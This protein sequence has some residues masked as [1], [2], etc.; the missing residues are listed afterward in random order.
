M[1]KIYKITLALLAFTSFFGTQAQTTVTIPAANTAG[2]GANTTIHRK[3]LG[4]RDSYERTALK[5][6]QA[7]IGMLGNITAIG[8][9]CDTVNAPGKTPVKIYMKEVQDS[10]F[11]ASTVAA[12]ETNATLVYA[13][14]LQ[15]SS[16]VQN[17][18]V[19]ITLTTPFLHATNSNI[20]IIVETNTGGT[21][22]SDPTNLAKGFRYSA[23]SGTR[24]EYWQ[25]NH[26]APVTN[27]NVTS[28]NRPNIQL[29]IATATVC[30]SP[31][32]SGTTTATAASVCYGNTVDL[33]LNGN[34]T[35]ISQTYQWI[36]SSD[37]TTWSAIS[38]ATSYAYVA[39][40]NAA[41]YYACVLTCSSMSDTSTHLQVTLN[42]FYA[43]YCTNGIG[44]GCTAATVIDSVA[45]AGTTL[46]NGPLVCPA[47]NYIAYPSSGSTTASLTQGLTYSLSTT[48][49][50][51]LISSVW[52]DYNQN[53]TFETTEWKQICTTATAGTNVITNLSIP[54]TALVGQT[55]MRIRTRAS[56]SQNDSTSA[57]TTFGSGETQDYVVTIVAGAP[58]TAP[59]TS[60]TTVASAT[61]ICPGGIVNLSLNGNSIGSGQTFQWQSSTNGTTWTPI[62]GATLPAYTATVST[63][64]YYSCVLTCSAQSSTSSSVLI[65]MNSFYQCYCSSGIG[66][67]CTAATAIDS[68]AITGSTLNNGP[69]ACPA[70]NYIEYPAQAILPLR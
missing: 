29:T 32:T 3:P 5:Y 20:E 6:T 52:I 48:F 30:T 61:T 2:T 16:F 38:G 70:N 53:G 54:F 60:G 14:T 40:V 43:C 27:G 31:P 69:L 68:V 44:G 42:P 47:N 46:N 8:F 35:G 67:G 45:I 56:G 65:N 17:S 18:W 25:A 57:C 59:P 66:G 64:T 4:S 1:K 39:T 24:M 13:D 62:T 36:S 34:S 49:G 7:E 11:T 63:A 12:E 50:G 51:N 33:T 15:A 10:T 23:Q 19:T 55:G 9:Y 26:T 22:G 28:T 37:G 21:T 58:C 41:T